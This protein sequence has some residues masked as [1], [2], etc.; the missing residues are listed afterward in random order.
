MGGAPNW[1]AVG[2]FSGSLAGPLQGAT[3]ESE[4]MSDL[5]DVSE[6]LKIDLFG[7]KQTCKQG[8][9][10]IGDPARVRERAT[11]AG[12]RF[13]ILIHLLDSHRK[14][15]AIGNATI[16]D[17]DDVKATDVSQRSEGWKE[18]KR[19]SV[20][21]LRSRLL[22]TTGGLF[23]GH[24]AE[25]LIGLFHAHGCAVEI[26]PAPP[27][28]A[29][30]EN[31]SVWFRDKGRRRIYPAKQRVTDQT[32]PWKGLARNFFGGGTPSMEEVRDGIARV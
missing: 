9:Q 28:V 32:N 11:S 29:G 4:C 7:S 23:N 2:C 26:I 27:T 10:A 18:Q 15:L 17:I 24:A 12:M 13:Q 5:T 3:R 1:P 14:S 25:D 31:L 16:G 21:R 19:R 20:E 22:G 30:P 8:S 6:P